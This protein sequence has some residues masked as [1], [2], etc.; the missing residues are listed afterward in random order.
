MR[1]AIDT[2][3]LIALLYPD[4]RHNQRASEL[5]HRADS[6]GGLFIAPIVRTELAADPFFGDESALDEFLDGTGLVT[7]A[8][9]STVYFEAGKAF[10]RY[11]ERRGEELQCPECG[12]ETVFD[13]PDCGAPIAARQ[14]V[15]ADF[16]IGAHAAADCDRLL[17][18]DAGFF[19]DY[20]DIGI[21]TVTED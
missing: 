11:I 10:E 21:L 16:I 6:E 15:P 12:H 20:F 8:P 4:D 13:C 2:S 14:H 5:L 18:F 3:A 19:R 9:S 17:S 7:D 1:T